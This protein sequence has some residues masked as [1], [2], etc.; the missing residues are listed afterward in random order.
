MGKKKILPIGVE[1]FSKL[2]TDNYYYVD[3]TKLIE[4]LL[5]HRGDAN[6]FTRPRRFGKSLSMNMLRQFF[7]EGTDPLLFDGLYISS[8]RELCA[9]YMGQYPVIAVSLKGVN[10]DNFEEAGR[11]LARIISEE[12]A[13]HD[14]LAT[15]G[16]LTSMEKKQFQE[17]QNYRMDKDTLIYSLRDLSRFLEKHSGKKVIVLIDE[18]DVPLAKASEN[19]YYNE[20]VRLIRNLFENALKTNDS[21]KFSVLTGCLRVAKESIFTGLNNFNVYSI[22]DADFDEY[23]GFTDHEVKEILHYYGFDDHYDTVRQWYDGYRFGN[24]DV[25]CPWDVINYC[26][27]H[28]GNPDALPKNYWLN[29]SGNDVI[30]HF[31]D[32]TD[33]EK[34]VTKQEL[35][36]LVNG[37][38]VQKNICEEL[39]YT[40][41][42]DSMDNLWSTLYMTG[43]LTSRGKPEPSENADTVAYSLAIPNRE[44]RNI[45]TSRIMARFKEGVKKDGET[46]R[47]FCDALYEGRSKVV[48]QLFREYMKK[49]VSVRDTF[50]R[51]PLK[52]N[53]Y[54]G[55]LHGILSFKGGWSVRSNRE[56]GN[57]F[58]DI[59]VLIDD[60]DT[61]IVI[62]VKYDEKDDLD[63]TCREALQQ[64]MDVRYTELFE[65]QGVRRILKYGIACRRKDCRVMVET[66]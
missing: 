29:T 2:R 41:L 64:I 63:T 60:S 46:V 12:A 65:Q 35:E 10:A 57:G 47:N 6:L 34:E 59:M 8:N 66:A 44:V 54:H 18:Y 20:M 15:S 4:K 56:S 14:F 22:T 52:E 58:S 45:I 9:E 5:S 28:L 55:L 16:K 31:I 61:G 51:K 13:R 36:L 62:E 53:F 3:K 40:E 38:T 39:T 43:Y 42:Y 21:L 11:Y 23:F 30:N 37:E 49:T 7:E 50:V 32:G 19:G 27:D 33:T 48:E 26:S 25:Y 24:V 17:I 1:N